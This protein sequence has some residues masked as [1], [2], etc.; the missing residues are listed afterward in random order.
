M[1][2]HKLT[3]RQREVLEVLAKNSRARLIEHFLG[4]RVGE[5]S[6]DPVHKKTGESLVRHDLVHV[7]GSDSMGYTTHVISDKGRQALDEQ[8]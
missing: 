5:H 3:P 1:K 4:W 2:K 6:C 7:F 8:S